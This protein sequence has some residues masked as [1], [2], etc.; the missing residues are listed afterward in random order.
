MVDPKNRQL[1]AT[2][3]SQL[4]STAVGKSLLR[5]KA[6]FIM[7]RSTIS[8]GTSQGKNVAAKHLFLS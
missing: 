7:V 2:Y 1:Q 5:R 8:L 6:V 3:S 4:A